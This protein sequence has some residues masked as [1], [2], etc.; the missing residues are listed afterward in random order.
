MH[1]FDGLDEINLNKTNEFATNPTFD[2]GSSV[3]RSPVGV[4]SSPE[5]QLP[6]EVASTLEEPVT[7]TI[8]RCILTPGQR[9]KRHHDEGKD[10]FCQRRSNSEIE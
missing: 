4:V 3:P 10:D 7:Q 5:V 1:N 8:V 2:Q 9:V 6:F